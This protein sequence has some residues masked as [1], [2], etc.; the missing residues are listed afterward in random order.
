MELSRV[1]ARL[2]GSEINCG[3][4]SFFDAGW[5]AW[6]GDDANGIKAECTIP[7]TDFRDVA[8]WLDTE[9]KRLY[10]DSDYV[11]NPLFIAQKQTP[12]YFMD[13]QIGSIDDVLANDVAYAYEQ[14]A[15][16]AERQ[17]FYPDTKVGMRQ[18][19]VKDQI[20]AAI[21]ERAK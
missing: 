18:Q 17:E 6:I 21:R 7:G 14:A 20:A 3:L 11:K 19:W 4:K 12:G 10:P 9:A 8:E 13:E 1:L 5:N 2:Y 15:R 16:I